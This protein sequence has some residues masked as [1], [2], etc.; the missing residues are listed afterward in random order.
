MPSRP[1]EAHSKKEN[2]H[3]QARPHLLNARQHGNLH[4]LAHIASGTADVLLSIPSESLTH[5]TSFLDPPDLLSLARTCKSLHAHVADDNTWRRAY[6]YQYLGVT[7]ESDLRDDAGDRTLM[8][9]REESSWKREFVLRYN[10]KRYVIAFSTIGG[11]ICYAGACRCVRYICLG[12]LGA[13]SLLQ[14]GRLYA[15]II[16][17]FVLSTERHHGARDMEIPHATQECL[18]IRRTPLDLSTHVAWGA[19]P[20]SPFARLVCEVQISG[21]RGVLYVP[22]VGRP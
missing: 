22:R 15:Q 10:L 14:C 19:G 6:V 9:R 8:L 1:I 13:A 3:K 21:I 11:V 5:V 17:M 7:P 4:G 12:C 20:F 18:D 2:R 16:R